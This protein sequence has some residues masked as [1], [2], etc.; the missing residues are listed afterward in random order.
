MA[1]PTKCRRI[2]T[3]PGFASFGPQAGEKLDTVIMT[4]DEFEAIRLI[5]LEGLVQ[6]AAALRMN[7]ARTTVQAIYNSA[8]IKLADCLVNGKL[9][10]ILAAIMLVPALVDLANAVADWQAFATAAVITALT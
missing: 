2:C 8:R 3:M 10:V 6:E 1:R 7:V 9:L 4:V 5:D